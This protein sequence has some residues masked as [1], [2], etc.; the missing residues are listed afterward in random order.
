M[1]KAEYDGILR[2]FFIQISNSID[3]KCSNICGI[4][5]YEK[6]M[7]KLNKIEDIGQL[8]Y[9]SCLDCYDKCLAKHYES[10]IKAIQITLNKLE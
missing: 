10:S 4:N 1:N 5:E 2:N 7:C 6:F 9:K 3:T 8:D